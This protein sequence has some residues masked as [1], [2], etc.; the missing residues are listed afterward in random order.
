[1]SD[2]PYKATLND[3]IKWFKEEEIPFDKPIDFY[4]GPNKPVHV[5]STYMNGKK[6]C[7]D[8]E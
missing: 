3:L 4:V 7:V 6:V 2:K 5:A 1:M 8:L